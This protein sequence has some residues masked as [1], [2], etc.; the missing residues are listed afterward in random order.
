L[1]TAAVTLETEAV[2][3]YTSH[4]ICA[5]VESEAAFT[6]IS[7]APFPAIDPA[8][9]VPVVLPWVM[10]RQSRIRV[11]WLVLNDP[12]VGVVVVDVLPPVPVSTEVPVPEK[13]TTIICW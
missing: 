1:L 7:V 6:A 10:L 3:W 13:S 4:P 5:A 2:A 12:L 9:Q 11:R 8:V